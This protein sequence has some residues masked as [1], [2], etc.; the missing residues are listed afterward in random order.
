MGKKSGSDSYFGSKVDKMEQLKIS[1]QHKSKS[2]S[3][4]IASKHLNLKQ[5]L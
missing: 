4:G 1:A 5:I 2:S 3:Y